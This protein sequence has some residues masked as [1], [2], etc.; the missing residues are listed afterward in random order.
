MERRVE[1]P[2]YDADNHMYEQTDAFTRYLPDE[3]KNV[4]KFVQVN[5]RD[6]IAIKNTISEYIP[7][8]TF[9][10]VAR[11]GAQEDYFKNGNPEGKSRKEIIGEPIR[12]PEAFFR[13]QPRLELMDQQGVD[14]AIMWPTL[15]SVLEERLA[16]DPEA[17]HAVIHALNQWMHE[18]WTFNYKGRIFA[19]PVITLPIVDDAIRELDWVVE[20]GAKVILIRPAP[21]PSLK[22]YRSF[23]L[24][25][26]DPFWAK[27]QEYDVTV[28]MHASDDGMTRYYNQWEGHNDDYQPFA[29]FSA[30]TAVQHLTSRGIFD[31]MASAICHGMLSRFPS[32]RVLP[33][34]NGSSW[35][36]PLMDV[37]G[38][39]YAQQPYLF[40][41][42]PITVLRRNIWIHPFFE[43]DPLGLIKAIGPDRVVFGSDFPHPEGLADPLSYLKVIESLPQR[44]IE[45]IMGGNLAGVLK[46]SA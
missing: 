15:A 43:E 41:E 34:E 25:E 46:L 16:S 5:G 26:F 1:Y 14:G 23:A 28:G 12:S 2:I 3:Y 18:E 4:I 36:I 20:H 35:V 42:D 38:R 6:K 29:G 40:E 27:V 30:F 19:A 22:G 45:K 33:V 24:P 11:P 8:P 32:L 44:D 39:A 21:V 37:L 17:T 7:N 31:A 10:K 13:P 9:N